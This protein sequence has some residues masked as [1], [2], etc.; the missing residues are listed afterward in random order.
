MTEAGLRMAQRLGPPIYCTIVAQNYLPQALTLYESIQRHEPGRELVLFVVDGDRSDLAE[1][2]PHLTLATVS[3]LGLTQLEFEHLAM[4]YDV[5]ELSTAVKPLLLRKLLRTHEWAAY[6][7]PDLYLVA[8]LDELGPAL[9]ENPI[10]VTPHFLSPIAPGSS[11]ISEV[12]SL[13]VGVHNLGFCGVGQGAEAFLDWW[14]SHLERECLIYPLLGIFVDQKWTDIGLNLFQGASLRHAG[15]NV[16]PWNLHERPISTEGGRYVVGSDGAPLRLVHFSGF[17]PY[18]PDA[19]SVRLNTDL[20]G[21]TGAGTAFRALSR[22]YATAQLRY[23]EELGSLP[24]Y[25]YSVDSSGRKLSSRLRRTYRAELLAR[26]AAGT[27]MP[28]AFDPADSSD[29]EAWRRRSWRSARKIALAD[30]A[31]AAKYAT[32]DLFRAARTTF[33]RIFQRQRARL[34]KAGE[35]RR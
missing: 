3:D 16:G 11:Y 28:S 35:V 20:R 2:R 17:N 30:T 33:P 23:I 34:L 27:R 1:T 29:Y 26:D 12:H 24:E 9:A 22:E 10:A 25:G 4:I 31:I 14:W 13:T 15:Y 6:L 7:D 32:P 8:P 21:R 18:D 19:I 5:V